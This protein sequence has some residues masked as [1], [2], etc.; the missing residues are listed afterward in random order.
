[1]AKG[2]EWFGEVTWYLV[3]NW[4]LW[5]D[6]LSTSSIGR[7]MMWKGSVSL[8][9]SCSFSRAHRKGALFLICLLLYVMNRRLVINLHMHT[10]LPRSSSLLREEWKCYFQVSVMTSYG[11]L[12][13]L[14]PRWTYFL[15]RLKDMLPP[16]T[17]CYKAW[18]IIFHVF[19]FQS[20]RFR[21]CFFLGRKLS[22]TLNF[23]FFKRS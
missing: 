15:V 3:S 17:C 6:W 12:I 16:I 20:L 8:P 2:W 10:T 1:M 18:T 14:F 13:V 22:K 4:M 11:I 21:W 5:C 19:L 9:G 7:R 23:D